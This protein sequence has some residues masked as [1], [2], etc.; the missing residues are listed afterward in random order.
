M[1]KLVPLGKNVV[2]QDRV[3]EHKKGSIFIPD[4]AQEKSY[5]AVV[6][7]IGSDVTTIKVDD[8]IIYG[9][10]SGDETVLD[11]FKFRLIKDTDILARVV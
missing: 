5:E 4:N 9:K 7:A 1:S 11:G 8:V 6:V 3:K 2:I 10:F